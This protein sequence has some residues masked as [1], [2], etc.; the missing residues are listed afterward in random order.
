MSKRC[1]ILVTSG[2]YRRPGRCEKRLGIKKVPIGTKMVG[3][4]A[5][6]R[7]VLERGKLL[8]VAS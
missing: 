5:H 1:E 2:T 3:L 4:C 8:E 7:A 6:H